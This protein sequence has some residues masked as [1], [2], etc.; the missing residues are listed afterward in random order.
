[1]VRRGDRRW[2]VTLVVVLLV[3]LGALVGV[4]GLR[5]AQ[6]RAVPLAAPRAFP[7]EGA[8]S[9]S[10]E[11]SADA[12]AHSSSQAVQDVL[13]RYFEAINQ[14]NY[15]AWAATVTPALAAEQ[16]EAAWRQGYRSTQDGTIRLSRID[17]VA[18]GRLVALV[19]FVSAQ[20][21]EDAPNRLNLAQICWRVSM[22]L[23]GDPLRVD[24]SKPGG[25]LQ[26][27]CR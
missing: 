19:S 17:E 7:V 2:A 1:M 5:L 23:A 20:R 18:P 13:S 3:T 15:A 25:V 21:P 8:G 26:G 16:P 24:V 27:K 9:T 6:M 14:K 11:V 4:A 10:L 12:W 22:P